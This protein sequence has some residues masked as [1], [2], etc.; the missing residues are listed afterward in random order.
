MRYC[1]PL[2]FALHFAVTSTIARRTR[3]PLAPLSPSKD[4]ITRRLPLTTS[5]ALASIGLT[6]SLVAVLAWLSRLPSPWAAWRPA[7]CMATQ[8]FCEALRDSFVRQP[9]NAATSLAFLAVAFA[10]FGA[11]FTGDR[12]AGA[13]ERGVRGS[14]AYAALYAGSLLVVGLG[15]AFF[16]ASLTFAGQTIDVLGMYLAGTFILLAAAIGERTCVR[17]RWRSRT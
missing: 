4:I 14:P 16:H 11:E 2:A 17:R 8:C 7:S 9:V 3:P 6:A 12:S 5:N 13:R 10:V 15:S 1:P